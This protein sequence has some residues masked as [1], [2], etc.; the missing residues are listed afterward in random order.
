MTFLEYQMVREERPDLNLPAFDYLPS[1]CINKLQSMSRE[2]LISLRTA[3]LL[4]RDPGVRDALYEDFYGWSQARKHL[5]R[6]RIE[7]V[8]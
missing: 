4:A 1:E 6:Q 2:D 3:T 5:P 7:P 8:I